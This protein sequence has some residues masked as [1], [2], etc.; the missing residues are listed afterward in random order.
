MAVLVEPSWCGGF[1]V[2]AAS[3]S[4]AFGSVGPF[5]F[6]SGGVRYP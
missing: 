1:L 2:G 3:G 6:L 4:W 5:S